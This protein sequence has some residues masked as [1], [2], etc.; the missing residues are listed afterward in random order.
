M[1]GPPLYPV[2]K[3]KKYIQIP[4]YKGLRID[5]FQCIC[6]QYLIESCKS[7]IETWWWRIQ[8]PRPV[9]INCR[10]QFQN[11]WNYFSG[12]NTTWAS[13]NANCSLDATVLRFSQ[14]REEYTAHSACIAV[15]E[16]HGRVVRLCGRSFTLPVQS[17]A[18]PSESRWLTGEYQWWTNKV[19]LC[20]KSISHE[21]KLSHVNET[22]IQMWHSQLAS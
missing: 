12:V 3:K 5:V 22:D 18:A 9:D 19:Y 21:L 14:D 6:Y 8:A 16:T 20:L 2:K 10:H 15:R 11:W 4:N 17:R 13:P 1:F 7:R